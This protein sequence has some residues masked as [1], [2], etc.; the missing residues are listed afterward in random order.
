ML[1]FLYFTVPN[2]FMLVYGSVEGPGPYSDEN[3]EK[4]S[5]TIFSLSIFNLM[6]QSARFL[7]AKSPTWNKV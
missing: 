1:Y 2:N 3:L 4:N 7:R 6:S 5:S